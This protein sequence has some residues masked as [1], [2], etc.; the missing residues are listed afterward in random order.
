MSP[1]SRG[2]R[3]PRRKRRAPALDRG[4][5]RAGTHRGLASARLADLR[6]CVV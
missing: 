6:R 2:P 1:R 4:T 5:R 3:G